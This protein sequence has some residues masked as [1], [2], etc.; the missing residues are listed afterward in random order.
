M[1]DMWIRGN[2]FMQALEYVKRKK[3][4]KGLDDI[5]RHPNEY[6]PEHKYDFEEF[7]ELLVKINNTVAEGELSFFP[8]IARDMMMADPRWPVLFRD[9]GPRDVFTNTNRQEE[10]YKVGSFEPEDV[11]NGHITIGMKMFGGEPQ[12][13]EMW[14]EFYKGRLGAILEITG[15]QGTVEVAGEENGKYLYTIEWE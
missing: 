6:L 10:Q 7:C 8:Q 5:G 12:H 14:A 9:M 4:L 3:G 1:L 2:F 15:H 13:Q 11:E